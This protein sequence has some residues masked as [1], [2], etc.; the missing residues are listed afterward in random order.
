MLVRVYTPHGVT[1]PAGSARDKSDALRIRSWQL[2]AIVACALGMGCKEVMVVAP[3]VV[4]LYNRAFMV[5]SFTQGLRQRSA[6][7]A[8]LAAT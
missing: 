8:G 3:L 2:G 5:G 6:T 1:V 7:Y 4:L